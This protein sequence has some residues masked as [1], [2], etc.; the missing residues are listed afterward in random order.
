MGMK[1]L[2]R[3][4]TGLALPAKIAGADS[5]RAALDFVRG[6]EAKGV[7]VKYGFKID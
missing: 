1:R 6:S 4:V 2:L 7:F 5:V 3:A